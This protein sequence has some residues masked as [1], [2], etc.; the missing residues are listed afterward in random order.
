ME[1]GIS[2]VYDEK[3]DADI[4]KALRTNNL[5]PESDITSIVKEAEELKEKLDKAAADIAADEKRYK[6][7]TDM[8]KKYA[9][10]QFR[11]GDKQVDLGGSKYSFVMSR[12]DSM[13]VDEA[14]LKKAGLFDQYAVPKTT[15]TLRVKMKEEETK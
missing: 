9:Q 12:T 10:G 11:D 6:T 14:A 13:K 15:Y 3:K 1:T 5:S 4:L 8:L 2:P 7:L